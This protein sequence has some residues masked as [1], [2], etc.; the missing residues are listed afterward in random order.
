[1]YLNNRL[2]LR[3]IGNKSYDEVQV[4]DNFVYNNLL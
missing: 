2:L 1:M 3:R 4:T